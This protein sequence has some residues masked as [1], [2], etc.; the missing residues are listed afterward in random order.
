MICNRPP[1]HF[2]RRVAKYPLSSRIPTGHDSVQILAGDGMVRGFDNGGET[3]LGLLR[4]LS[5][6][7]IN[8]DTGHPHRL[9][10]FVPENL[11]PSENPVDTPVGPKRAPFPLHRGVSLKCPLTLL[12][13]GILSSG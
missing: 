8:I 6:S 4:L 7:D 11:P 9:T 10:K 12:I 13:T 1:D 5:R 2:L 3:T